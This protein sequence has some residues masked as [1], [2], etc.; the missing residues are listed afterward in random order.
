MAK[1]RTNTAKWIETQ[2]RWQIK[3]QRDGQRRAFCSSTPGRAGQREQVAFASDVPTDE[4]FAAQLAQR[5]TTAQ[6]DPVHL[7][8]VALDSI[9]R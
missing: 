5:C 9:G 8:D 1:E 6:L 4:A 2:Q 7:K 3:V